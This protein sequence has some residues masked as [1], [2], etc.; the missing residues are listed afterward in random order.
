[1]NAH[2]LHRGIIYVQTDLSATFISTT[3]PR[4]GTTPGGNAGVEG[5]CPQGFAESR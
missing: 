3:V 5:V 4:T 2:L 1:M